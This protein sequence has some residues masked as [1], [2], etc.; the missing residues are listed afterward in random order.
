[1]PAGWKER[2]NVGPIQACSTR[3][4]GELFSLRSL[5]LLKILY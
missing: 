1:M 3:V 5:N 4:L 2:F